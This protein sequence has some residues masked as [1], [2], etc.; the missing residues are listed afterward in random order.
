MAVNT[1]DP[2]TIAV[3]KQYT[4]RSVT[5][6]DG[7]TIGFRQFGQGPGLILLHGM[8]SSGQ[9]HTQLA[10]AL[11]DTFTV[12]APDRRGRG[13]SGPYSTDYSIQKEVEDL[14]AL[15]TETGAHYIFGVSAGGVVSLKAALTLPAIH[16]LAVF[17]PPLF[18]DSA[19][20]AAL[21]ARF[22]R[23]MA[24]GKQAAALVTAMKGSQLGPPIFNL[25]PRRLLEFLTGKFMASEEKKATGDYLPM[26]T[27]APTLHY[28]FEIVVE[29]SGKLESFEAIHNQV[30]LLG[31]SKSPAYM[32]AA[33]NALETILP[34]AERIELPGVGHD[35]S[36][37]SDIGG[38]PEPVAREL[39]RFFA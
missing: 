3:Q 38:K 24:Q 32:K 25:M 22:D 34:Q 7:T 13:L 6:K 31:G 12:Y 26:R 28:D 1:A 9:N 39:H 36:W 4:T 2:T 18:M 27:L 30:L 23:E 10:S 19:V 33:L 5:S 21:L 20:P 14:D 16:K 11:A 8:M 15:L 17:E 37:N 29:M 35:A